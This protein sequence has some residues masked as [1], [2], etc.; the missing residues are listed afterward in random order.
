MLQ[1]SLGRGNMAAI[2]IQLEWP[3][4]IGSKFLTYEEVIQALFSGKIA[5]TDA[6]KVTQIKEEPNERQRRFGQIHN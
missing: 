1:H 3:D 4:N 5:L 2:K 6:I